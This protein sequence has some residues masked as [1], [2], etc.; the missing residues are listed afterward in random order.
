MILIDSFS[1]AA[2]DLPKG[3]RN[4]AHVLEV[5]RKHPRVS[6]WDLSEHTWLRAAIDE[7]QTAGAITAVPEAF[8]W[9]RYVVTWPRVAGAVIDLPR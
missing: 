8:P 9:H 3:R 1:G 7:L 2:A 4:A 5:L 6:T